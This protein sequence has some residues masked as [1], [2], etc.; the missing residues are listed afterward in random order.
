MGAS[1][2]FSALNA[3]PWEGE[4][5]SSSDD[6]DDRPRSKMGAPLMTGGPVRPESQL[7]PRRVVCADGSLLS[8][9]SVTLLPSYYPANERVHST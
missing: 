4:E 8:S 6:D 5:D 3:L 9:F 7:E 2:L 1:A